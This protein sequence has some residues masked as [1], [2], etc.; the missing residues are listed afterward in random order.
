MKR[1]VAPNR[2]FWLTFLLNLLFRA[3]WLMLAVVLFVAHKLV[4]LPLWVVSV[5]LVIWVGI[6]LV[7]TWFACWATSTSEIKPA[8]NSKRS[9]E[10]IEQFKNEHKR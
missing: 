6:A 4:Q 1:R 2:G 3:E 10:R 9:S 7:L 8:P 5:P